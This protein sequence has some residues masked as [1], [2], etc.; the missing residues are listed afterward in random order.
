MTREEIQNNVLSLSDIHK[1]LLLTWATGTGKSYAAIRLQEYLN[2]EM[3]YI[4]VAEV[5][6]IS[7]WEK[8][9]IKHGKEELLKKTKIFC[10]ASLKKNINEKIDLLIL[11]EGHHAT[12]EVRLDHLTSLEIEKNVVVLTA[13]ISEQ[14]KTLLESTFG[15]FKEYNIPLNKAIE[16]NILPI[17][18]VY[19]IPLELDTKMYIHEY[20]MTRGST[21]GRQI[22]ECK[23]EERW[24]YLKDK[25]NYPNLKLKVKCT[26]FQKN[27][28]Y[29]E[30]FAYFRNQYF[31]TRNKIF[32]NKWL[33]IGSARKRFLAECKTDYLRVLLRKLG[34]R[35]FICF[36]GSI[37][38]AD[39]VSKKKNV[40]HSKIK[41]PLEVIEQFNEGKIDH[42]FAVG[43]LKEGQNLEDIEVGIISQLDGEDLSFIQKSGRA[44]RAEEPLIFVLYYKETRDEEYL[45]NV[46]DYINPEYIEIISNLRDWKI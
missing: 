25:K 6:H 21:K 14:K 41:K 26:E 45:E 24:K 43:M 37:E 7:N 30:Q 17:P 1:N 38:Q 23:F 2:P 35:R 3:T 16:W 4:V 33:Q 28:W 20:E 29:N 40:I 19:L 5:A 32:E 44:L 22:I 12:S 10:Y 13:T 9:Y 36:C 11:D 31:R 42:I 39:L 34:K 27:I 18:K 15:Q 8:E 46:K